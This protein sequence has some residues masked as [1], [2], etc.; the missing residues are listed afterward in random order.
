MSFRDKVAVVT[1]GA[2]GMGRALCLELGRRGARV[3]VADINAE[4]AQDC[5]AQITAA[6]GTARA[7]HTDVARQEQVQALIDG[8]VSEHGR[9]DF[10]FNNAGI[11]VAGEMRDMNLSHWRRI[12][13]V[14]L[15]GVIH[16]CMA[17]YPVML[18]QGFGHIV[19]TASPNGMVPVPALSAYCATKH[20][21]IGL[22][23]TLAAEAA[24]FGIKVSTVCPGYTRSGIFASAVLL[25]AS[26]RDYL[27]LVP[28]QAMM[29]D[30]AAREI[31]KGVARNQRTILF[32]LHARLLCSLQ[33]WCPALLAAFN[34]NY[35]KQFRAIRR[36]A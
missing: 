10:L 1:G 30:Y 4:G 29:P 5:A 34:K 12:I 20:A 21:V 18:K 13:D 11:L 17:A 26:L 27:A 32:P 19:N 28:F 7:V 25:N 16:G 36:E 14:N 33:R 9:L 23:A 6:G 3:V 2:S 24:D 8:T 31:L 22:S 15:W 35:L